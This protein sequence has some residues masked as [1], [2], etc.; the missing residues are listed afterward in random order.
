[1]SCWALIPVKGPGGGKSRLSGA[2]DA[3]ARERLAEAM[4]AHVVKVAREARS[5]SR[6]CLVGPSRCG[7]GEEIE[8]LPD[9]AEGLNPAV[10]SAFAALAS[11]NPDRIL[12]VHGDLPQVTPRDLDLLAA[13]PADTVAIA[14]DRHGTGTNALSLPLPAAR[15]FRFAFGIDSCALHTDETH[16]LGLKL[17]TILSRGLEKDIDEPA[18]LPDANGVMGERG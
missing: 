16:R 1:V 15:N 13:A 7:I 14:P 18:D 11:E 2:L 17:E 12:I 5:I 9:P 10:Q 6:V 3:S 8:L 4:L